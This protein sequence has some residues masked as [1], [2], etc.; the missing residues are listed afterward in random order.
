MLKNAV[1]D[2]EDSSRHEETRP[3]KRN[4]TKTPHI[5][6]VYVDHVRDYVLDVLKGKVSVSSNAYS[7]LPR[8][9]SS[10]V[11]MALLPTV[12][13]LISSDELQELDSDEVVLNTV[14]DHAMQASASSSVKRQT[15][16]FLGRIL[17]VGLTQ[18]GDSPNANFGKV[19]DHDRTSK[20]DQSDN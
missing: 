19:R 20:G 15:I 16:G 5:L 10:S 6:P 11:Y 2:Q 1:Q 3:G 7:T 18:S 9:I 14:I 13:A 17:L 4:I 12:W 8:P